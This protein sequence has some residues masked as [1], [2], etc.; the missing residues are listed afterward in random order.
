MCNLKAFMTESP[1]NK[2]RTTS[3]R[4]VYVPNLKYWTTFLCISEGRH[5]YPNS[6]TCIFFFYHNTPKICNIQTC[7]DRYLIHLVNCSEILPVIH[8][9]QVYF[10]QTHVF[11][12]FRKIPNIFQL[13][14]VI[15]KKMLVDP[16]LHKCLDKRWFPRCNKEKVDGKV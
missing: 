10:K 1:S 8:V 4:A 16:K 14:G 12:N 9:W 6:P 7:S 2:Q 13:V 11:S 5:T 15:L 3:M